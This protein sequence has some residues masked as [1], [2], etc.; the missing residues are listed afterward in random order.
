[1]PLTT[2]LHRVAFMTAYMGAFF[3]DTVNVVTVL[4]RVLM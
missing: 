1:M 2:P 4:L 3:A